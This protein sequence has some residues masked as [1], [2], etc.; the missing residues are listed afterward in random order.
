VGLGL[1]VIINRDLQERSLCI[2]HIFEVLTKWPG[3]LH[4]IYELMTERETQRRLRTPAGTTF[5]KWPEY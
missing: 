1:E 4:P 2:A 5:W 3:A